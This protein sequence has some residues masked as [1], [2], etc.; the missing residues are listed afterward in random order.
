MATAQAESPAN[1][2]VSLDQVQINCPPARRTQ[3]RLRLKTIRIDGGVTKG[4]AGK[5]IDI[6]QGKKFARDL[7]SS[8]LIALVSVVIA[9]VLGLAPVAAI[10]GFAVG[11]LSAH[12]IGIFCALQFNEA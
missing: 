12:L 5:C 1:F 10:T 7:R 8:L 3:K 2:P 11:S 6:G 4:S 9:W